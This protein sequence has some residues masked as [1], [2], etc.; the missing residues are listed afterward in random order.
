MNSNQNSTVQ[1]MMNRTKIEFH[2]GFYLRCME[3][4]SI[5]GMNFD[6]LYNLW[7]SL[8]HFKQLTELGFMTVSYDNGSTFIPFEII[9]GENRHIAFSLSAIMRM[10]RYS[11]VITA[12][13]P[14][15]QGGRFNGTFELDLPNNIITQHLAN[16]QKI[17]FKFDK[18]IKSQFA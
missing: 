8:E 13:S 16:G 9:K 7:T 12:D 5:D 17:V 2:F 4:V 15:E 14:L 3:G 18:S 10:R 11:N 6:E 1:A